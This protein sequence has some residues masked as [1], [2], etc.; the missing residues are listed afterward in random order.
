MDRNRLSGLVMQATACAMENDLDGATNALTQIGTSG[1]P[2]DMY[3]ACCGF[4]EVGKTALTRIYGKRAA[5]P[6][7]GMWAMQELKPGTDPAD[8][9]ANRFL[10]AYCNDDKDM[11]PVLFRTAVQSAGDQYVD[12]VCALLANVTGLSRLALDKPPA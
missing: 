3:A 5:T 4:A 2:F 6:G 7:N 11:A 12:S 10:I 8:T 9:F 1:D